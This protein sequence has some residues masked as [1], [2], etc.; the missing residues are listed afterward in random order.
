[1]SK[2]H[3]ALGRGGPS[4]R[5]AKVPDGM[6]F[7]TNGFPERSYTTHG[8]SRRG[9]W[10]PSPELPSTSVVE[11]DMAALVVAL[12][13]LHAFL[14]FDNTPVPPQDAIQSGCASFSFRDFRVATR[15]EE[16]EP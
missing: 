6:G 12:L 11:D 15:R 3:C 16:R 4:P 8:L 1:M 7:I 10:D 9:T 13:G 2:E 5:K 14:V